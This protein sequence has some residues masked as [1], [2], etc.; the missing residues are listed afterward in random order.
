MTRNQ[1]GLCWTTK[2]EVA[3]MFA[4]GL[5]AV[6]SDGGVLLRAYAPSEAVI[7]GP[8]R[9]SAYLG[10]AEHTV[11]PSDLTHMEVLGRFPPADRRQAAA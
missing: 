2:I 9:H 6:L 1:Y 5:N 11:D 3:T 8:G 10:E 4:A 7:S